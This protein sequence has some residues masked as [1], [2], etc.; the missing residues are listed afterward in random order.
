MEA[1]RLNVI[2]AVRDL[3]LY[4][5]H[6]WASL[7]HFLKFNLN[8]EIGSFLGMKGK[9]VLFLESPSQRCILLFPVSCSANEMRLLKRIISVGQPCNIIEGPIEIQTPVFVSMLDT[10]TVYTCTGD[11]SAQDC[12]LKCSGVLTGEGDSFFYRRY[13]I[14]SMIYIKPFIP[15]YQPPPPF[16]WT[17]GGLCKAIFLVRFSYSASHFYIFCWRVTN[18]HFLLIIMMQ[19]SLLKDLFVR[20]YQEAWKQPQIDLIWWL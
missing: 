6:D 3:V 14:A 11:S 17:L 18:C 8:W 2:V 1:V 9:F 20:F 16:R 4:Y 13:S 15:L 12:T 7:K 10:T 5:C 19:F